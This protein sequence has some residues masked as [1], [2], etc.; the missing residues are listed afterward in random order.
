MEVVD[1]VLIESDW[2]LKLRV[3]KRKRQFTTVLIESDWN[4]KF[5]DNG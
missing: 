3:Q 1:T 5:F 4:L 2:N